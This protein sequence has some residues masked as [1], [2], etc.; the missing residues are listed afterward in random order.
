MKV[1]RLEPLI[2][3][4]VR[5]E[6][7]WPLTGHT[8]THKQDFSVVCTLAG[9]GQSAA[10][11]END[12]RILQHAREAEEPFAAHQIGSI[13]MPYRRNSMR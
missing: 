2:A 1:K 5:V 8:Y 9:I 12:L 3:Q 4:G 6:Q 13:T 7:C 10:K 11:M